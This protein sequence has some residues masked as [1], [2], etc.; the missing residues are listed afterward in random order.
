MKRVLVCGYFAKNLGDDLFFK[1]LFDRYKNI[2]WDL[3]TANRNYKNI[4]KDYKN[5]NIIY[6]YRG[7]SIGK[8]SVN[9]FYKKNEILKSLKKYDAMVNICGSM[10]MQNAAWREKLEERE[11]LVKEFKKNN[12]KVYI[13]GANF[14]PYKDQIFEDKY[15]NLFKEYDD[16][17]FRENY[18]FNIFKDL[19]NVRVAPDIVFTLKHNDNEKVEKYVGFS[20]IDIEKRDGL[21]EHYTDYNNKMRD[22]IEK[23]IQLGYRIRLFSFCDNEGDMKA[24]NKI[25]DSVND[26]FKN[27][28]DVINYDGNINGF[29]NLFKSCSIIIGTRFHSIILALLFNQNVFPIIYSDKTFNVLEDLNANNEYCYIKDIKNLDINGVIEKYNKNF[30]EKKKIVKMAEEHFI[31]LDA[32]LETI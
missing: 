6:S 5:V 8:K 16:I 4:F 32:Y 10:F 22:L 12:K 19:T 20:I 11:Y 15:R 21:K 27:E 26:K 1:V 23:Y 31:N 25:I 3:L 30:I 7:V 29:I 28:I 17:C 2:K 14:G 18:S 24:I 13:L 9:L